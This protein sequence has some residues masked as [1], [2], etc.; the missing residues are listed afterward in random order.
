[1]R[2]ARRAPDTVSG[3]ANGPDLAAP[4][5]G[6]VVMGTGIVSV[7]LSLDG[8]QPLSRILLVLTA[9]AWGALALLVPARALRNPQRFRADARKPAALS[10][11]AGTAVLGTRFVLLGWT[12]PGVALFVAALVLW[13]MLIGAVL[14]HWRT[15]TVGA[16]LLL[17]VATQSLAVLAAVLAVHTRSSWLEV[18]ALVPFG[19]GVASYGFVMARFDL[20]QL[21]VGRGDQWIIGGALAIS[22][23][24]AGDLASGARSLAVLGRGHGPLEVLAVGLWAAS[25]AWLP[26]LVAAEVVHP[27][28]G[29]DVR[30]WS[31]VFPLGM[32]AACSFVV[33]QLAEVGPVT[34]FARA[35]A[36]VALAG[37]AAV[38]AA[39]VSKLF[40]FRQ[41]DSSRSA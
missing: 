1:L 21:I 16:S 6:A 3:P 27:R 17:T 13:G 32:Y 30:R 22:T 36:W 12:A 7:A 24:A 31:T 34:S 28:L 15:P 9:V 38:T 10:W 2:C 40:A 4:E 25:I 14:G 41:D 29:Y 33:G 39:M 35:W 19:L 11:V 20:R 26:A 5:T 8:A 37:W 18:G 23:L